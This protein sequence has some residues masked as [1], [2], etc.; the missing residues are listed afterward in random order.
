MRIT[1]EVNGYVCVDVG[2]VAMDLVSVLAQEKRQRGI[3]RLSGVRQDTSLVTH[4]E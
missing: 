4:L 3:P 2:A 1:K